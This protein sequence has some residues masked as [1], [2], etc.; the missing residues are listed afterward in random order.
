S[1]D[2]LVPW[3]QDFTARFSVDALRL[4]GIPVYSD[5]FRI[6]IPNAEFYVAEAC[7]GL[8]FLI[9]TIAFGVLFAYFMF[10]SWTRKI[11]FVLLCLLTPIP[12]NRFRAYGLLLLAYLTDGALAAGVDHIVYGWVFFSLVT[13]GLTALGWAMRDMPEMEPPPRL[14][15]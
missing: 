9:A 6:S 7:A 14:R 8:R 13:L 5:G 1:G 15:S 3:L 12:A 11:L 10:R 2:F 4:S